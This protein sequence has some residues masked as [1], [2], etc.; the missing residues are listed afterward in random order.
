MRILHVSSGN[1]YGGIETVLRTL[2]EALYAGL[3]VVTTDIG[4]AREIIIPSCGTLVP[5]GDVVELSK[6][7]GEMIQDSSLRRGLGKAGPDRAR[8]L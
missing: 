8:E 3:P 4:A 5:A 7:L 6:A 2:G 1:L